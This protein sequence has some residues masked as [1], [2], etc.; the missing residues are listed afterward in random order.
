MLKIG[1]FGAGHLGK[2]HLKLLC[3]SPQYELVGFYDPR[4]DQMNSFAE[5]FNCKIYTS[6]EELID[7]VEVVDIV[8][9]TE[10]HYKYAFQAIEKGKHFFVEKP[11]TSTLEQAQDLI[12]LSK[13]KG[14]LAQVGH[15]ERF[16]PAFL[17]VKDKIT[18]PMFIESHR[19]AKFSPRGLDVAVISDLMIHDLDIVLKLVPSKVSSINASG[20]T[21]ISKKID[22]ASVR[23]D[24]DNGC[25]ANL[26][27][28][29]I[30]MK[31]TRKIRFFQKDAYISIDFLKKSAEIIWI[32]NALKSF[33]DTS[34]KNTESYEKELFFESPHVQ[35]SN[36]ILLELESF[37][38]A[39]VHKKRVQVPLSDGE[40]ALEIALKIE[41]LIRDKNMQ[42]NN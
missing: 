34:F 40:K 7:A 16:N 41:S 22:I 14:V 31:N 26:T 1:V 36:A 23:I 12:R 37:A 9:P 30:S 27:T 4:S 19:L 3:S 18:Q 32:D 35:D 11:L 6:A 10:F 2:T 42:A 25:V 21:V 8:T 17:A 33:K 39:I 29:R 38:E 15:V 24:F 13:S 20:V 28:S 5:E